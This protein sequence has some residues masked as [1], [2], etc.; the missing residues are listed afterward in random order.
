MR[1]RSPASW[2]LLLSITALSKNGFVL[3]Q[4]DEEQE[5]TFT[6]SN[7]STTILNN[8]GAEDCPCIDSFFPPGTICNENGCY[9]EDYGASACALHDVLAEDPLCIGDSPPDYCS[10]EWC[11]VDVNQCKLSSEAVFA[12]DI[13]PTSAGLHYSYSTC[14]ST[15]DAWKKHLTTK[16]IRGKYVDVVIPQI[17]HPRHYK[18]TESG[19]I[20]ASNSAEYYNDTIP[21]QGWIIDYLSAIADNTEIAGFNF[22]FRS[23]GTFL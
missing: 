20:A 15:V 11:Y 8:T 2:W 21:W 3:A 7:T 14:N 6:N 12:S 5:E 16:D 9:G 22:T 1:S 10:E 4:V 19:E 13:A 17:S 23:R 18:M